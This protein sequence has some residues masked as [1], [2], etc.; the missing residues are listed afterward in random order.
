MYV[1]ARC[2]ATRQRPSPGKCP[3]TNLPHKW[4][5]RGKRYRCMYCGAVRLRPSLSKCPARRGTED[6][7]HIFVVEV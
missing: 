3:G 6:P 2:G 7:Y 4:I 5:E 1:C